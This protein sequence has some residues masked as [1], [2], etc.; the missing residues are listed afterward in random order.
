[1]Y[2]RQ[3]KRQLKLRTLNLTLGANI[4]VQV[5][6][7]GVLGVTTDEELKWQPHIDNVCKQIVRNLFLLGKLRNYV[8][9]DRRKLL[10]KVHLLAD[11]LYFCHVD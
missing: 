10:F 6:Q 7:H 11:K 1:M 9:S 4:I 8:D 2:K 3:K 5:R